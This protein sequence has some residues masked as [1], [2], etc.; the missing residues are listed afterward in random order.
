VRATYI[1]LEDVKKRLI[2]MKE[3]MTSNE[4]LKM[5]IASDALV[6]LKKE[7]QQLN[8]ETKQLMATYRISVEESGCKCQGR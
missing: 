2:E 8:H 1:Y 4:L 3:A 6:A 5:T 7:A